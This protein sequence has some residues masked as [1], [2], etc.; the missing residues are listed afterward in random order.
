MTVVGSR[1]ASD[2]MAAMLARLNR[3]QAAITG[4]R[5]AWLSF[6]AIAEWCARDG[7]PGV[8]D[9]RRAAAYGDLLQSVLA[10]SFD[11]SAVLYLTTAAPELSGELPGFR[12][13]ADF[14]RAHSWRPTNRPWLRIRSST[15]SI[16][17]SS[18]FSRAK[19]MRLNSS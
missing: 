11:G 15:L 12:M 2:R 3:A 5:P 8:Q 10:G 17:S 7:A 14:I 13:T 18:N 9:E 6:A 1:E 4:S 16:H 19:A